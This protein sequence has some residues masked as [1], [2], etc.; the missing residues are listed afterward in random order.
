MHVDSDLAYMRS[1]SAAVVER[2]P[3]HLMITVFVI[4]AFFFV[5]LLWMAWAQIDV[6]VR[7]SGKVIPARQVQEVQSL[8][9]GV[10]AEILVREGDLVNAN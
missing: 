4:S 7:G 9:G 3:K 6:V 10:V 5:T 2:S 1:L 8:E